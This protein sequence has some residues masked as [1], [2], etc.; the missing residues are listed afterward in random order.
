[1]AWAAGAAAAAVLA[2]GAA[3]VFQSGRIGDLNTQMAAQQQQ[4][5]TLSSSLQVEPLQQAA[6]AALSEPDAR[7]ANL[8][9]EGTSHAMRIVVRNDGT[10]YVLQSSLPELSAG[11]TYQLWAVVDDTVI[12]AGVL[13]R[14]PGI[15]PFHIDP[16]GLRGLVITREVAGGVAQSQQDP[17]VAWFDA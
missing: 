4:I 1:M 17:V 12:S 10:G 9:G 13:G 11:S 14:N 2:L 16:E 3:V 7:I 6:T 5:A 15:V 8:T